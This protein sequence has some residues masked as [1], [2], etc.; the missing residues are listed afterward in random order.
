MTIIIYL[1]FRT[2]SNKLDFRLW[3]FN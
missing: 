3:C 1:D 2:Y